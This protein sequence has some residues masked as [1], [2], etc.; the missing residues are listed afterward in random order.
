[1][2]EK[3]ENWKPDAASLELLHACSSLIEAYAKDGFILTVRQVYYQLV[4]Q[5]VIQ[6]SMANYKRIRRLLAKGRKAGL[7]DW[8]SIEDRQRVLRRTPHW[9][10]PAEFLVQA[11]QFYHLD[12]WQPTRT[13][14]S[15]P[16]ARRM[17]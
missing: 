9:N 2:K 1:M 10:S 14:A 13:T 7:I 8:T 12:R 15:K 11:P 6:K 17:R 3:F 4:S 5:R 16:G